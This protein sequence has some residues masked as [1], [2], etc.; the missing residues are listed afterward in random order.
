MRSSLRPGL[1][2]DSSRD[3]PVTADSNARLPHPLTRLV[4]RDVESAALRALLAHEDVRF[5]T[6]TGPGGIGKTRLAIAVAAA[7]AHDFAD[8][9]VYI[10]LAPQTDGS[11]VIPIVASAFG[12]FETQS[13]R[14]FQALIDALETSICSWYSTTA[15]ASLA[16]RPSFPHS[17][18][19]VRVSRSSPPAMRHFVCEANATTHWH[20]CPCPT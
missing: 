5:V 13:Q 20:H 9:I 2:P 12:V 18:S 14:R 10:D 15:N 1:H 4:G 17:S 3:T 11:L 7:M 16:L 19:R 6:V 8:G